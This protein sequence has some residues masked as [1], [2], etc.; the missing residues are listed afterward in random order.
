MK[1][2]IKLFFAFAILALSLLTIISENIIAYILTVTLISFQ[3]SASAIVSILLLSIMSTTCNEMNKTNES[4]YN[5]TSNE[6]QSEENRIESLPPKQVVI[7]RNSLAGV[8]RGRTT[9]CYLPFFCLLENSFFYYNKSNNE[10]GNWHKAIADLIDKKSGT[11]KITKNENDYSIDAD[12][13]KKI[14]YA[15]QIQ[16]NCEINDY[17]INVV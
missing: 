13:L 12:I 1:L 15:L 8:F 3:V 17:E 7:Q 6:I 2:T 10:I 16:G 5:I 4:L 11:V 9:K 14:R